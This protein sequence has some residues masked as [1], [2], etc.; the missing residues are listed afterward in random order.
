MTVET[1]RDAGKEGPDHEG[2]D[3][4]SGRVE[5]DRLGSDLVVA[6]RRKPRP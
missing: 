4:V 1:A 3:L 2:D 5:P 6:G